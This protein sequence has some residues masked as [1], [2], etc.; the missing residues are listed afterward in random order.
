MWSVVGHD[1]VVATL[2]RRLE[3]GQMS[4]AYLF[5]G[6]VGVGKMRLALNIAQA[7]NCVEDGKPCG[8]CGQCHRIAGGKHA[9]VQ[10]I[11]V[12]H[13]S[14]GPVRKVITIEQIKEFQQA[15]GLQPY[16][17][18]HRVF[19]IDGAEHL[20]QDAANRLLKTLEEPPS[21][22]CLILLTAEEHAVLPT[23]LSR[24]QCYH[25]RPVPKEVI[26]GHLTSVCDV[27]P[28]RA[29]LL[30]GL[31]DGSIGWAIAAAQDEQVL[32]E[33]SERVD[34]ALEL[35]GL[36]TH[37]RLAAAGRLANDFPRRREEVFGW[38]DAL[39]RCWRDALL[40]KGGQSSSV[41]NADRIES[42]EAMAS[43]LS[44]AQIADA[45]RQVHATSE[46]LQKNVNPRIALDML[47]LS[48][49]AL[50]RANGAP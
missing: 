22:V 9:D 12:L 6:P 50:S 16:E 15:A 43:G 3:A 7:L 25:L 18:V 46:R 42:L 17:G 48:L 37:Q 34:E 41:I 14:E 30:A 20:S 23:I 4:H 32:E 36:S 33:L 29:R 8:S 31:A 45:L 1:R 40:V 13:D 35:P 26:E 2:A 27:E 47:M 10:I 11:G 39:R 24:C 5:D 38:L 21:A 49:P 19:I 28:D 44:S